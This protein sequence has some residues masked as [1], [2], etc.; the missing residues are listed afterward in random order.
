MNSELVLGFLRIVVKNGSEWK[1][2]VEAYSGQVELFL[3]RVEKSL[4]RIALYLMKTIGILRHTRAARVV[5]S[6]EM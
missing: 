3:Q 2:H 6:L 5:L 1:V 4:K